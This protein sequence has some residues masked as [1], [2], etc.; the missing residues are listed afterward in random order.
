MASFH[1]TICQKMERFFNEVPNRKMYGAVTAV[2]LAALATFVVLTATAV[3]GATIGVSAVVVSTVVLGIGIALLCKKS[4]QS[5]PMHSEKKEDAA[6]KQKV[7]A[8]LTRMKKLSTEEKDVQLFSAFSRS[9]DEAILFQGTHHLYLSFVAVCEAFRPNS[10]FSREA[11]DQ[12]IAREAVGALIDLG[13]DMTAGDD[14][15]AL[16]ELFRQVDHPQEVLPYLQRIVTKM[17]PEQQVAFQDK[18]LLNTP[19]PIEWVKWLVDETSLVSYD[20][21]KLSDLWDSN[22]RGLL[23]CDRVTMLPQESLLFHCVQHYQDLQ[24]FTRLLVLT[25]DNIKSRLLD[26]LIT[27]RNQAIEGELYASYA[28]AITI[29]EYMGVE[30]S[31]PEAST[32]SSDSEEDE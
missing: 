17:S 8:F 11:A 24:V 16:R 15:C 31:L 3:I 18:N 25:E 4:S 13:V 20:Q 29:L 9:Y 23:L 22:A 12:R 28:P 19:T 30:A 7:E 26:R 5:E 6:N 10:V 14:N 32:S 1:L 27:R 21:Y 2:A